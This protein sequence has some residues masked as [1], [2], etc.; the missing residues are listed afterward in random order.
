MNDTIVQETYNIVEELKSYPPPFKMNRYNSVSTT[1]DFIPA[2]YM[3][4]KNIF[5][6]PKWVFKSLDVCIKSRVPIEIVLKRE[7]ELF[8]AENENLN[9]Y[10]LGTTAQEAIDEFNKHIIFLFHHYKNAER[11]KLT[12]RAIELKNI[13]EEKFFE[14]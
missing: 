14:V 5:T 9:I 12:G 1:S 8:T 3:K 11:E 7:T 10:A 4:V 13:F 2:N 6:L